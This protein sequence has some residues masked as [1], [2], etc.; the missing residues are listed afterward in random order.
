MPSFV[1]PRD[2]LIWLRVISILSWQVARIHDRKT[3]WTC[4]DRY[5]STLPKRNV[6]LLAG[7]FNCSLPAAPGHVGCDGFLWKRIHQQGPSHPD[8]G[9][10]LALVK[11][12]HLVALN[13]WTHA[14]GPTFRGYN[15]CSRIDFSFT[16]LPLADGLAKDVKLLHQSPFLAVDHFGHFPMV[17]QLRRHW[18]FHHKRRTQHQASLHNNGLLADWPMLHKPKSGKRS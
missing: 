6:L 4:L 3:W 12:H 11:A 13:S 8:S 1:F 14:Q 5:L 7:D 17:G 2:A 16:R 15:G 9:D 10:F 18:R